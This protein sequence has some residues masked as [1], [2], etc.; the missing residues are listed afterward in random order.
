MASGKLFLSI[1]ISFVA[2]K[3]PIY[4]LFQAQSFSYQEA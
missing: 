4:T 2:S 3:I 1:T